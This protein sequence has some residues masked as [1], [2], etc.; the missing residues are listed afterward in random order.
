MVE[1]EYN[2]EDSDV[3]LAE[4]DSC[5]IVRPVKLLADPLIDEVFPEDENEPRNYCRSCFENRADEI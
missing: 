3:I 1:D 5:G 2:L 4:C